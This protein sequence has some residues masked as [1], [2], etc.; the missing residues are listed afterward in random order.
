M[1]EETSNPAEAR[2]QAARAWPLVHEDTT[3]KWFLISSIAYFFIV[4]H[5][6][7]GDRRQVRLAEPAGHGAST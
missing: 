1:P 5:H 3:A 6:R 7:H 2:R 4:G